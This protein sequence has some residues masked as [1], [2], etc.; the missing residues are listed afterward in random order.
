[1]FFT[2]LLAFGLR[3]L[4]WWENRKLDR[5]YGTIEDQK[6]RAAVAEQRGEKVENL[7]AVEN[8]GPMYRYVL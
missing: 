4:L 6:A 7:T 3:T 8:Y 5:Q 1:M 2:T